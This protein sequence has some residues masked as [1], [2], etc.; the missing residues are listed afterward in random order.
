ME[1]IQHRKMQ[2]ER[3]LTTKTELADFENKCNYKLND[4]KEINVGK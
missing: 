1:K 2:K 3:T 4:K